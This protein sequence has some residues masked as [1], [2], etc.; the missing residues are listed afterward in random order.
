MTQSHREGAKALSVTKEP[1]RFIGCSAAL[2]AF[3]SRYTQ[4]R[5]RNPVQNECRP[6]PSEF[7]ILDSLYHTTFVKNQQL[8]QNSGDGSGEVVRQRAR[9]N[10]A[11]AQAREVLPAFGRQR[12]DPADLNSYGT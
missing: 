4:D 8:E 12:P 7:W 11:K 3:M 2:V 6:C 10:G 1:L 9:R 5:N